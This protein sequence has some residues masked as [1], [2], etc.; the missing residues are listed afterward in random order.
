MKEAYG[1]TIEH[2]GTEYNVVVFDWDGKGKITNADITYG[3]CNELG[4]EGEEGEIREALLNH[5]EK[6]WD[7]IFDPEKRRGW[8][9]EDEYV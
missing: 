3:S 4:Y 2:E 8:K 7:R 5:I 6:N 9:L 1:T